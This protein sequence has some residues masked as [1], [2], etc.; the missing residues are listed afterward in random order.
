MK[1]VLLHTL[2]DKKR[3]GN[4]GMVKGSRVKAGSCPTNDVVP[5][6]EG[7]QEEGKQ[8]K[9]CKDRKPLHQRCL[10]NRTNHDSAICAHRFMAQETHAQNESGLCC[11]GHREIVS[12]YLRICWGG[13]VASSRG[14]ANVVFFEVQVRKAFLAGAKS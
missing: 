7:P 6:W 4:T 13:D 10:S 11:V 14:A 5:V 8:L 12:A 2:G 9:G 1:D 3:R